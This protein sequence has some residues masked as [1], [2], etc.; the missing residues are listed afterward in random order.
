[1]LTFA[2]PG[3]AIGGHL[4]GAIG[5]AICGYAMLAPQWKGYPNWITYVV[6]TVVLVGSVV[7]SVIVVGA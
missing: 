3:I 7:A 4:G 1:M 5:G 2:I 6:P